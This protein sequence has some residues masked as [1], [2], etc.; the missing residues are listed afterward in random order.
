MS[1]LRQVVKE[2]L[3]SERTMGR[4][5]VASVVRPGEI[6]LENRAERVLVAG[7]V[8]PAAGTLIP[9]VQVD[10][11]LL[12]ASFNVP[13]QMVGPVSQEFDLRDIGLVADLLFGNGLDIGWHYYAACF[14]PD[15]GGT[16]MATYS[17]TTPSWIRTRAAPAPV[18]ASPYWPGNNLGIEYHIGEGTFRRDEEIGY[19][20]ELV[21]TFFN[22]EDGGQETIASSPIFVSGGLPSQGPAITYS[23]SLRLPSSGLARNGGVRAYC[24]M[25]TAEQE[26]GPFYRCF[27]FVG[28]DT[29]GYDIYD[30]L[31]VTI[32]GPGEG[33]QPPTENT[34]NLCQVGLQVFANESEEPE[35]RP[36]VLDLGI[37]RIQLYRTPAALAEYGPE[38]P[39]D[40]GYIGEVSVPVTAIQA[41]S[42][43]FV[44]DGLAAGAVP[45]LPWPEEES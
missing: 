45:V 9:W 33:P 43:C 19:W 36:N 44:D 3:R 30:H 24:S 27:E 17:R 12:V 8:M 37:S 1:R 6:T 15:Q 34:L 16:E 42:F 5:R 38:E 7:N 10:K 23:I 28:E 29:P 31:E 26:Q 39:P 18:I 40:V 32:T 22:A 4:G 21:F 14:P 13:Q 35:D 20:Y 41:E 2:I 11:N 25:G